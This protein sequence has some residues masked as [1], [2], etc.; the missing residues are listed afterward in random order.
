MTTLNDVEVLD[1]N[2]AVICGN[3][4]LILTSVNG[5][6]TWDSVTTG[7]LNN[8]MDVDF[9]DANTGFAAGD[10]G[11]LLKTTNHGA[12]WEVIDMS[13]TT[14]GFN[15]VEALDSD[16]L[17]VAGDNGTIFISESGGICWFAPS[18]MIYESDFNDIV[19]YDSYSGII[20]GND[21]LI[22]KTTDA[23]YSWSPAN[24]MFSGDDYDLFSVAFADANNGISTGKTGVEVYTTDGGSTWSEIAPV[25]NPNAGT[26]TGKRESKVSL[27]QNFPNPFNPSTNISYTLPYNASVS[28]E[29][30]DIT[31]KEVAQLVNAV[32]NKGS[33][34]VSFNASNLSSGVYFYSI[35]VS[36]GNTTISKVMRMILA[37]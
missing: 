8:L 24:R 26:I 1:N 5:G 27:E 29:I 16:R 10:A 11:T 28:L 34:S 18:G 12:S 6:S 33:H 13:F 30:F 32:E 35:R 2:N 25:L 9:I 23:G 36:S 7:T 15:S 4:G 17:F 20:A 21:G 3:G 37:K 19:F 31:G 22:L 14:S